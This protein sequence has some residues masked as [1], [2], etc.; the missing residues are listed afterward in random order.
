MCLALLGDSIEST[1]WRVAVILHGVGLTCVR[2]LQRWFR[3][4]KRQE[5][6]LAVMML[7]HKRLAP[8]MAVPNADVLQ[9]IVLLLKCSCEIK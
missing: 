6:A 4:M 8:P 9:H 5:R 7:D 1:V 3:R 2:R